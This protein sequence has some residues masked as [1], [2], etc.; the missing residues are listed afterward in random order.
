MKERDGK[1]DADNG[2]VRGAALTT[3][4]LYLEVEIKL[5]ERLAFEADDRGAVGVPPRRV[6]EQGAFLGQ[7]L[8]VAGDRVV[9]A[10]EAVQQ[11]LVLRW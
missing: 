11:A 1:G 7:G 9:P 3:H 4:V 6:E 8:H 5:L 10:N 2:R